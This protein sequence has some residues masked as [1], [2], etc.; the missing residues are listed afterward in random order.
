MV[1]IGISVLENANLLHPHAFD[2]IPEEEEELLRW[3]N[4]D[5][6]Y[7]IA[8]AG[9]AAI[10]QD[11]NAHTGTDIALKILE[12]SPNRVRVQKK[13]SGN[14][15]CRVGIYLELRRSRQICNSSMT[16]LATPIPSSPT[17]LK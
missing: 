9:L 14:S 4:D 8:A 5:V 7:P 1:K 17:S 15:A 6:R 3:C 11:K 13:S 10:R 12:K 16:L 2:A